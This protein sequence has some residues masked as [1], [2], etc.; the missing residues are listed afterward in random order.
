MH[1][2]IVMK[3]KFQSLSRGRYLMQSAQARIRDF[4]E[5]FAEWVSVT[6]PNPDFTYEVSIIIIITTCKEKTTIVLVFN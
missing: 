5:G 3:L 6:Q 4:V 2:R 1:A